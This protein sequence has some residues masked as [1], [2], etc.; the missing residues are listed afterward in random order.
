MITTTLARF[1]FSTLNCTGKSA[2]HH[3]TSN[4]DTRS[5][6]DPH[7]GD[8]IESTVVALVACPFAVWMMSWTPLGNDAAW[9]AILAGSCFLAGEPSTGTGTEAARLLYWLFFSAF[10]CLQFGLF[11]W[12]FFRCW[13]GASLGGY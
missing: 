3:K 5:D 9:L 10:F 4:C 11:L 13:F 12:S 1:P 7:E 8:E 6:R 2:A